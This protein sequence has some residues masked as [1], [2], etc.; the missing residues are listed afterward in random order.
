MI[1][2]VGEDFVGKFFPFCLREGPRIGDG[3][4][5]AEESEANF[6]ERGWY[7]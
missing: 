3:H 5:E 2:A 1:F 7:V 4:G 6:R